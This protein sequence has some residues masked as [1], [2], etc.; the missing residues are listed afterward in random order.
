MNDVGFVLHGLPVVIRSEDPDLL[1]FV[2]AHF[3]A[4]SG[5]ISN[6]DLSIDA[7]WRWGTRPA[8]PA[9]SGSAE[10]G[11]RA[12]RGIAIRPAVRAGGGLRAV[13]S[14]I[15]DFPE[16]ELAYELSAGPSPRLGVEAVCSYAP[17][18][19][20]RKLEY[21][22]AA[23]ADR[24]R[25][26]LFFKMMYYM[27]YYPMSWHLE[28]TRGWGLLHGSAVAFPTGRAVLLAGMGGVGKST[29]ALSLLSHPGARMVSD[30]LLYH[31][32]ERIYACPEPVRLDAQALAGMAEGGIEP[33]RSDLP[34]TA[35]PKPTYRVGASRTVDAAGPSAVFFLRFSSR[36][37]VEPLP[38][39]RAA[40]MLAA[41][42]AL[43]REIKDYR[44]CAALL[45]MLAAE[46]GT[47]QAAP[48]ASLAKL[49]KNAR[50]AI[51]KI[52]EGEPIAETA[53]RLTECVEASA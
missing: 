34:A 39:D 11:D 10:P 41:G 9:G 28:R 42:D 47:P 24:K 25:N 8:E 26:R 30:N 7:A 35:H 37:G 22:R 29:L 3:E 12:G 43:A 38:A 21:L 16:L 31:D 5:R 32:E 23:R 2:K 46:Q 53:D 4:G 45:T 15:P 52:G 51:F 44:P 17:R 13:W 27:V 48:R 18:G 6:A 49:L 50:C 19:L 33:E 14:R 1:A 20:G 36:S 40:E